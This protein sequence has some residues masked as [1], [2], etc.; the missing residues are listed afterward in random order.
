MGSDTI[1]LHADIAHM[2]QSPV[3]TTRLPPRIL[4]WGMYG[5]FSRIMLAALLDAG[6]HI[7]GVILPFQ[8]NTAV[9]DPIQPLLPQPT[10]SQLPMLTPYAAETAVHLAWR[11]HIPVY[12]LQSLKSAA[13]ASFLAEFQADVACV[14][15]FPLRIPP[16]ILTQPRHG[17]LNVHPSLLPDYRGPAPLFWTLRAGQLKTGVTVHFMD[18]GLDTG[19]IALQ[20]AVSLP[21]GISG[22]QADQLLAGAGAKLLVKALANLNA[23]TLTRQPQA[24]GGSTF[25]LPQA[26]DF[27]IPSTWPAKRAFIFMRGT[28]DWQRP[29]SI[30]TPNQTITARSALAFETNTEQQ[31]SVVWD[32]RS[33]WIQ[34]QPGRLLVKI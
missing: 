5:L 34:L 30:I 15:C 17:F 2:N 21:L 33:C 9:S 12:A 19:D 25:P 14:A 8:G 32:G 18:A 6:C 7:C 31:T 29:Y 23:G 26:A 3:E 20:T 22:P 10:T 13:A 24:A 11:N 28:A 27:I 4:F 16:Q 1:Q